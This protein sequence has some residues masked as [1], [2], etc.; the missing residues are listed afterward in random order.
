MFD[1]KELPP[2]HTIVVKLEIFSTA[3]SKRNMNIDNVL[4]HRII[5]TCGDDNVKYGTQ[6]VDPVLCLYVGAYLMCVIGNEFLQE[7]VPRGSRTLCRLVS[8]KLR[9]NAPSYKYTN[10]YNRK[11]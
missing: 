2:E 8:M 10:Y 11:V 9:E 6:K 5:T 1:S 7:K 4:R 3:D